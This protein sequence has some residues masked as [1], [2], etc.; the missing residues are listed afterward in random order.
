[1]QICSD[2]IDISRNTLSTP[3]LPCLLRPQFSVKN[4]RWKQK[5]TAFRWTESW[6]ERTCAHGHTPPTSQLHLTVQLSI[7]FQVILLPP[8][9]NKSQAANT[10]TGKHQVFSVL[11]CHT[12][13]SIYAFLNLWTCVKKL[14]PFYSVPLGFFKCVTDE[15]FG[16]CG[17]NPIFFPEA[18]CCSCQFCIA[19][20]FLGTYVSHYSKTDSTCHE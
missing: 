14:L 15:G 17:L 4:T 10:S 16:H 5:K 12:Y 1:M 8:F 2:A 9:R 7:R 11:K 3:R 13:F 19:Q 18:L 6:R 20:C